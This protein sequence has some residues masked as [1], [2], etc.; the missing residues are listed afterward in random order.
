VIWEAGA[1]RG[2]K[3]RLWILLKLGGCYLQLDC[4]KM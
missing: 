1:G 2:R 3:Q 4:Y